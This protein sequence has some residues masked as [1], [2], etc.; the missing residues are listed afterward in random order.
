M[1]WLTFVVAFLG[2]VAW[3]V[4][5]IVLTMLLRAPI[6]A[7]IKRVRKFKAG[8][9]EFELDKGEVLS[10]PENVTLALP[11]GS[12]AQP[13]AEPSNTPEPV[14]AQ[15]KP[16]APT[17]PS[18][19]KP[20]PPETGSTATVNEINDAIWRSWSGIT[21]AAEPALVDFSPAGAI[22]NAFSRLQRL[23]W[24]ESERVGLPVETKSFPELLAALRLAGVL[25]D[26]SVMVGA[27]LGGVRNRIVQKGETPT[28]DAAQKFVD[29]TN[30][31]I[32][33]LE[34]GSDR[35][36]LAQLISALRIEH[37]QEVFVGPLR[38]IGIGATEEA[39]QAQMEARRDKWAAARPGVIQ[40]VS[41]RD[42]AL[43]I[44]VGAQ[45]GDPEATARTGRGSGF[46]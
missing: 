26:Q 5:S 41:A 15:P 17:K 43:L 13:K 30:E 44:S 39:V 19:E 23:V 31:F 9:T 45:R 16:E 21:T 46:A 28:A 25:D 33:R 42:A 38:I 4:T 34:E 12:E 24:N 11:A 27:R 36:R 7:A 29:S 6:A 2:K 3:P 32:K 37:M 40:L 10:F 14:P 1:D 22:V 8:G 35:A 20:S 18:D